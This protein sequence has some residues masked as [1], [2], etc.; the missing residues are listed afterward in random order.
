MRNSIQA[1]RC[2]VA[3]A[4]QSGRALQSIWVLLLAPLLLL[5]PQ[6]AETA[7]VQNP[8][9]HMK[10]LSRQSWQHL[11]NGN[12]NSALESLRQLRKLSQTNPDL[13]V[14]KN[15]ENID[16]LLS[17]LSSTNPTH[18]GVGH[19]KSAASR[20]KSIDPLG[21][22]TFVA[23]NN[24]A[25]LINKSFDVVSGIAGRLANAIPK[26]VTVSARAKLFATH[27]REGAQ[28]PIETFNETNRWEFKSAA[29]GEYLLRKTQAAELI[30]AWQRKPKNKRIF[31]TGSNSDEKYVDALKA[32]YEQEGY[33][34]Y[35]YKYCNPLCPEKLV[36][37]FFGTA[38]TAIHI[39][40]PGAKSSLFIPIEV[41]LTE[42]LSGTGRH[43]IAYDPS[44]IDV[45]GNGS[46]TI[47]GSVFSC[48]ENMKIRGDRPL[49][50]I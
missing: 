38:G 48:S 5:L 10:T 23:L 46:V 25:S 33:I 34:L 47:L 27:F 3:T 2:S 7:Y 45:S 6:S 44:E 14:P 41:A 35:F 31:V 22:Y 36:G 29:N 39:Q 8:A 43:V 18:L 42:E 17:Q 28:S 4:Y 24:N 32:Q 21:D 49:C 40:S 1:R 12:K 16:F 30:D 20:L 11:Q 13:L 50:A 26:V 9:T 37:A 19:L 15:K